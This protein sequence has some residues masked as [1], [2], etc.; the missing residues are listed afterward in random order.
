MALTPSRT[1]LA[2]SSL[3]FQAALV[4]SH[5]FLFGRL[6]LNGVPQ[7][8]PLRDRR[9]KLTQRIRIS[10][11]KQRV[12]ILILVSRAYQIESICEKMPANCL[13]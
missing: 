4:R 2:V 3:Y 13:A 8:R 12:Q 11:I 5:A 1:L 6:Q 7:G 10:P 9:R